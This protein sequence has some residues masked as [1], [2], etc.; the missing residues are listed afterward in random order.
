MIPGID[1]KI[2]IAFKKV[3][4]SEV[5]P[6]LTAALI[7]AVV[8]PAPWQQLA[9]LELLNP[10]SEKMMLGDKLSILDI[11]ARDEQGRLYNVEMQMVA[12]A[13]LTQRFLYY[14]SKLY[15]QQLTEGDDYTRLCPTISICFINGDVFS[16]S[17]AYHSCFRLLTA[18]GR[19]CL[20]EDL[21]IHVIE[22]PK[23]QRTLAELQEAL[24]FW[25]YFFKNG[26][27]LDA[28]ALPNPLNTPEICQAM[29]VLKM[30]SQNDM[31]REL[32]EGR[33]KA[34][35]DLLTLTNEIATLARERDDVTRERDDVTRERDDVARRWN[36]TR[37]HAEK[38]EFVGRI[39]LCERV[40][41]RP[42]SDREQLVGR[43][44]EDLRE[45]AERLERELAR[46]SE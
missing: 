40:L 38:L 43:S 2:D 20:T 26:I 44:A 14:W 21:V 37:Q 22:I 36:E 15:S 34:K 31:E 9:E 32:Y 13:A 35:R 3:L 24:D 10:Y 12:T 16:G 8:Q 23:F 7:N 39:Q 42:A 27:E 33:L 17:D 41:R 6:E 5:S 1:P 25:L 45:L 19:L 11:K 28:D 18:D 4:G 30:L 29:G 46:S